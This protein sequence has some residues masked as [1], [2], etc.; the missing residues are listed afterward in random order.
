[1]R[2]RRPTYSLLRETKYTVRRVGIGMLLL[3]AVAGIAVAAVFIVRAVRDSLAMR[4]MPFDSSNVYAYTGDGFLYS[5]GGNLSFMSLTNEDDNYTVPVEAKE[6][7]L[8]GAAGIKVIYSEYEM[9]ILNARFNTPLDGRI[10]QV[11]CGNDYVAVCKLC[12]DSSTEIRIYDTAGQQREQFNYASG[13]LID[14]GFSDADGNTIWTCTAN[15]DG[16][17]AGSGITT[18][19]IDRRAVTG[20]ISV[21]GQLVERVVFTKSSVYA[22]GTESV[23]R[24][25]ASDN[26][27]AY[28]VRIY[29]YRAEDV[30]A[31]GGS[32]M[33][34]LVPRGDNASAGVATDEYMTVKLLTLD[35]E[36]VA[37]ERSVS[38]RLPAETL[39]CGLVRSGLVVA[40][41]N[42]LNLYAFD[43]ELKKSRPLDFSVTGF[44]KLDN[45]RILL[46]RS[47]E[48]T[49]VTFK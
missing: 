22:I 30:V 46:E 12:A 31:S 18:Y 36:T 17:L 45:N 34:L 23:I 19:D 42:A 47:G 40:L 7:K 38:L 43:G 10:L 20:V 48:F 6:F 27:E 35:E 11:R 13:E 15:V 14:F 39:G 44:T 16:G 5:S 26:R 28:R 32:V 21:Q 1:M 33:L 24:Y 9:Q 8:T 4:D 37:D 2:R 41:P 25:S 49:L 29:G 3:L